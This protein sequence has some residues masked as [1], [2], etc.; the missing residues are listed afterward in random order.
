MSKSQRLTYI[1]I[2]KGIAI[3]CVIF[4]HFIYMINGGNRYA[5]HIKDVVHTFHMPLFFIVAGFF[6]SDRK[7]LLVFIRD[8]AKRLLIPYVIG[9]SV[10]LV[11]NIFEIVLR[12]ADASRLQDHLK[13]LFFGAPIAMTNTIWGEVLPLGPVWFLTALFVSLCIVRVCMN[14]R[15]GGLVISSLVAFGLA[16]KHIG[17]PWL[18]FSVLQAFVASAYVY[19]GWRFFDQGVFCGKLNKIAV[20]IGG[21][22]LCLR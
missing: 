22:H 14:I 5:R 3:L 7:P 8:K 2:A 20:I 12:G 17:L 21:G 6:L 19:I 1:D 18:P 16:W 15:Y 13:A 10:V 11:A 9:V 4:G